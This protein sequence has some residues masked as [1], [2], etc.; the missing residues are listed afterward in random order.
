MIGDL[1]WKMKVACPVGCKVSIW[2]DSEDPDH[3]L[4]L[5]WDWASYHYR[6][7]YNWY[8]VSRGI[9]WHIEMEIIARE[10]REVI[11]KLK[12]KGR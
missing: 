3:T 9:N 12:Q 5:Q 6:M 2:M 8:D 4:V 1:L 11:R 7:D 10:I